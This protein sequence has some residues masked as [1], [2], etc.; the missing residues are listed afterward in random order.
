MTCIQPNSNS[1]ELC[2]MTFYTYYL[3]EGVSPKQRG[4]YLLGRTPSS[5]QQRLLFFFFQKLIVA[6]DTP[7]YIP[8]P[9]HI[10]QCTRVGSLIPELGFFLRGISPL[11]SST[12]LNVFPTQRLYKRHTQSILPHDPEPVPTLHTPGCLV[13]LVHSK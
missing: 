10:S 3:S 13:N 11:Y 9:R 7:G 8:T 5:T 2:I 1:V 12:V 4:K 6:V